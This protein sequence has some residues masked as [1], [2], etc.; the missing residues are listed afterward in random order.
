MSVITY[1]CMEPQRTHVST[2]PF[3]PVQRTNTEQARFTQQRHTRPGLGCS[4]ARNGMQRVSGA[5]VR[6]GQPLRAGVAAA[7]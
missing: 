4:G 6:V 1:A 7:V 5:P 2:T 3:N